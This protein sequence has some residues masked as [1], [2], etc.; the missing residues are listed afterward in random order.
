MYLVRKVMVRSYLVRKRIKGV[1]ALKFI[2]K[3]LKELD[4]KEKHEVYW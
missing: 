4:G 3:Q 2:G 1:L